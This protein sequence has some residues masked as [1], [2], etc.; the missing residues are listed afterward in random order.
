MFAEPLLGV[1]EKLGCVT[2]ALEGVWPVEK[3]AGCG[4]GVAGW[5]DEVKSVRCHFASGS[6]G[7]EGES[8]GEEKEVDD[9]EVRFEVSSAPEEVTSWSTFG[10]EASGLRVGASRE[11]SEDDG[12]RMIVL[13]LRDFLCRRGGASRPEG[14]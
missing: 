5:E 9:E 2:L 14:F 3:K 13:T 1:M 10:A 8:V 6:M 11:S 12:S 4:V 7:E